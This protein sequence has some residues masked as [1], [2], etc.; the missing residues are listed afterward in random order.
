MSQR[1]LTH[2]ALLKIVHY[3]PDS[4]IFTRLLSAGNTKRGSRTGSLGTRGYLRITIDK[5]TY[6]A[7]RLAFFYM[8]GRWPDPEVDHKDDTTDNNKWN[9]LRECSHQQ[10]TSNRRRRKDC[11]SN[12]KGAHRCRGLS[13]WK[14]SIMVHGVRHHL[15]TFE[16]AE[17]AHAAY[18]AAATEYYGQF[19]RFS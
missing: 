3:D 19:A 2:S 9:N 6:L 17:L 7:H 13:R 11:R 10:N 14:S 5:R 8:T 16:T 15:G 1:M 4:G 18:C 12:L